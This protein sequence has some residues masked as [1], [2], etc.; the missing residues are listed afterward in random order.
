MVQLIH[1]GVFHE[2]SRG[3]GHLELLS[4]HLRRDRVAFDI[5]RDQDQPADLVRVPHCELQ[6]HAAPQRVAHNV[7]LGELE[8]VDERGDVIRHEPRVDRPIDVC[9]ASVSLEVDGDH[10]VV[11]RELRHHGLEHLG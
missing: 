8:V 11:R 6:R 3:P 10:L 7:G 4:E 5:R 9:G 1:G 2:L